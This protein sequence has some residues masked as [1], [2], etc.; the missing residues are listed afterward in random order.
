LDGSENK[1][2][3]KSEPIDLDTRAR[4]T[5]AA[6]YTADL[7]ESEKT[8]SMN[9]EN[10]TSEQMKDYLEDVLEEIKDMKSKPN[11]TKQNK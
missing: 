5:L 10:V 11:K 3:D 9:D 7:D 1:Q 6:S 4:M 8:H 2:K